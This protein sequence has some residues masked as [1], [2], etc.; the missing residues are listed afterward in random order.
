MTLR[1]LTFS[2]L[3]LGVAAAAVAQTPA[4]KADDDLDKLAAD[5]KTA[6]KAALKNALD[7]LDR[8]AATP[9]SARDFFFDCVKKCDFKH[10]LEIGPK[11]EQWKTSFIAQWSGHNLGLVLQLQLRHQALIL[12][13]AGAEDKTALIPAWQSFVDTIVKNSNDVAY[14]VSFLAQPI[15]QSVFDKAL[16][17]RQLAGAG[18]F[19]VNA[20]DIGAIYDTHIHPHSR[21]IDRPAT[22][23]QRI[24]SQKKFAEDTM[25]P[26]EREDFASFEIARL[27]WRSLLDIHFHDGKPDVTGISEAIKLIRQNQ[28]HPDAGQWIERI[29]GFRKESTEP[30]P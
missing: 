28:L 17:L 30:A 2:L 19:A 27:Q 13:S 9:A 7:Q 14:G 18:A 21:A 5:V 16:K 11:F 1:R 25:L 29:K 23:R 15:S 8:A 20:I 12:R 26:S 6:H 3:L 4:P 22:W 10:D 24:E